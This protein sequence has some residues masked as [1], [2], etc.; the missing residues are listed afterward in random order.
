MMKTKIFRFNYIYN[1]TSTIQAKSMSFYCPICKNFH[2]TIGLDNY[3][4]HDEF[5]ENLEFFCGN[6]FSMFKT[7]KDTQIKIISKAIVI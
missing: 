5:Y 1:G 3:T 7:V 6:C 2:S 4:P